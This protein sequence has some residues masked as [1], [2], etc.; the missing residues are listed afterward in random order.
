MSP[1]CQSFCFLFFFRREQSL[2][3]K[4]PGFLKH[5]STS[6]EK[7]IKKRNVPQKLPSLSKR[8][9]QKNPLVALICTICGTLLIKSHI[10]NT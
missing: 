1:V 5:S 3:R 2:E 8:Y 10:E 4:Y 6:M 7:F 9:T